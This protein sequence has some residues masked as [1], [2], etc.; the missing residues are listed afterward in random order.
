MYSESL[1][2]QEVEHRIRQ[3]IENGHVAEALITSVFS[4]ERIL[5]RAARFC[6]ISRGFTSLQAEILFDKMGFENLTAGW[7]CFDVQNR[8][9]AKFIGQTTWQHV[10]PAVTMRNKLVRGER[11][12]NLEECKASAEKVIEALNELRNRLLVESHFDCWS[13]LPV[14]KKPAVQWLPL[15]PRGSRVVTRTALCSSTG[16]RHSARRASQKQTNINAMPAAPQH[17]A[18]DAFV[19]R[20]PK[21]ADSN[22]GGGPSINFHLDEVGKPSK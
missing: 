2:S 13:R 8:S 15:L 16:A 12:H 22:V 4:F 17:S 1:G 20:A 10:P 7:P 21:P 18:I 11:L 19:P 14:R 9:L 6:A 5:R 3:L